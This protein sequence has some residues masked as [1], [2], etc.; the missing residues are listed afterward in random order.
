M[1]KA[2][3]EGDSRMPRIL[4]VACLLCIAGLAACD[5]GTNAPAESQP[6][7]NRSAS[8]TAGQGQSGA[9]S[10]AWLLTS[11]PPAEPVD[12]AAAK[13]VVNEGDRVVIRGRI[14]GRGEP[15]TEGSPVMV[16][17]DVSIPSCADNPEDTCRTP[18]DYCCEPAEVKTANSATIQ[19]VDA[20]GQPVADSLRAAGLEP[21]DEIIAV[22]VVGPR[23][24]PSVLVVRA[25]EIY[26]V[27]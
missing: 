19:V 18:W 15:M 9:A 21:L 7:S 16:I 23:P 6:S 10:P 12:V 4:N 11:A 27:E 22:G 5:G 25:T 3:E 14:G 20:Q 8:N 17:M 2:F 13:G 24:D 26:R 1:K